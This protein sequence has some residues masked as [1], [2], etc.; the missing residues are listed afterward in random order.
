MSQPTACIRC[1]GI[2][3][4]DASFAGVENLRLIVDEVHSSPAGARVCL[5]CGAVLLTATEPGALRVGAAPEP[6]IQ[7]FDF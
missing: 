7:E 4:V 6:N 1:K 5:S 3:L 2:H